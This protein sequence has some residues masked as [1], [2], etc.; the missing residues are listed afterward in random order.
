MTSRSDPR[1]GLSSASKVEQDS[2]C[3]GAFLAQQGIPSRGSADATKGT[4]RHELEEREVPL[5]DIVDDEDR[6]CSRRARASLEYVREKLNI[7]DS[8]TIS[9][10]LRFWLKDGDEELLSG[11]VD[12]VETWDKTALIADYKM[13]YGIHASAHNN[14]QLAA[15]AALLKHEWKEIETVYAALIEPFGE[16]RLSTVVFTSGELEKK[17][18]ELIKLYRVVYCGIAERTAGHRQCKFCRALG[19]CPEARTYVMEL[20]NE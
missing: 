11:Q 12:Y 18:S 20:I 4:E 16:P 17:I 13:L 7:P 15:Y 2:L 14:V 1:H 19:I 5:E 10:E 8:S 6:E 9:R 3:K